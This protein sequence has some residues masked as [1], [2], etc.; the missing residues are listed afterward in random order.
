MDAFFEG[1]QDSPVSDPATVDG[2]LIETP[3]PM[4]IL[5]VLLFWP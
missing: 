5:S 3:H 2:K 4:F 1:P